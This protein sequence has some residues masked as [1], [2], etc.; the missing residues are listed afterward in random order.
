MNVYLFPPVTLGLYH[1]LPLVCI[2]MF[3]LSL[4]IHCWLF[5]NI[6][7][8]CHCAKEYFDAQQSCSQSHKSHPAPSSPLSNTCP[9]LAD[10]SLLHL[11]KYTGTHTHTHIHRKTQPC[12]MPLA[13]LTI[14][15]LGKSLSTYAALL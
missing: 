15:R 2:I 9:R 5:K 1:F 6:I 7:N 8:K 13:T 10:S 14:L 3:H 12:L 11:R 4:C